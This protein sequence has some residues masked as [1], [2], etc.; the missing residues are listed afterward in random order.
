MKYDYI[1]K[2]GGV[3]YAAGEDVPHEETGLEAANVETKTEPE[4]P[5]VDMDELP[6]SDSDI[7]LETEP[8]RRGRPRKSDM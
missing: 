7:Q 8:A 1:V 6:F 5:E 4:N 2:S 3:Y